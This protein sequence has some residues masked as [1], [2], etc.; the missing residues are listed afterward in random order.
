MTALA[1]RCLAVS[2]AL[3]TA[4]GCGHQV[5]QLEE[6]RPPQT[7]EPPRRG[8]EKLK[9]P[10]VESTAGN[11]FEPHLRR[12]IGRH[13]AGCHGPDVQKRR[14]R[15]DTL[16]TAF[17]DRGV[18]ATWVKVLDRVSRGDMPPANKPRPPKKDLQTVVG[19]LRKHLHDASL[20][21]QR[22]EGR[23]V[24]RRLNRTEY[25]TTLRDLLGAPVEVKD[26]LPDDNVAAGFDNVSAVLDVSAAHL[27]R[28]QEAAERAIRSVIPD[29]PQA[30]IEERRTG[31]QVTRNMKLFASIL[32]KSARLDGDTL[33]LHTRTWGHIPCA[34]APA[35]V[36]G[37]YRVRVSA[38]AVGTGGKPLPVMFVCR[39][40]YG[41]EDT[42]VRG[43]RDVP[44]GKAA[45]VEGEFELKPRQV[46]VINGWSLPSERVPAAQAETGRCPQGPGP[47]RGLDRDQ[48][49]PRAVASHRVSESFLRR[50]AE[51]AIGGQGGSGGP[52]CPAA[53]R[54]ATRW[55]V[56]LRSAG[57]GP[58]KAA[59]GRRTADPGFPPKGVPPPRARGATALLRQGGP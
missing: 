36:A 59:P 27:L 21:R 11:D 30:A 39:D 43:V 48:R 57:H 42:D 19:T 16:P 55:L 29:R 6:N 5:S 12:F 31:R 15:L 49:S 46:I 51:A 9:A 52:P 3:V 45:V 17:D 35:P 54:Q 47:G 10:S 26:L 4:A 28:Y 56:D 44:A 14:L 24:L 33:I 1:F 13:C 34:T 38:A 20:A 53:A 2:L 40:L 41:R 22:R 58:E 7:K 37:R 25:Q 23:V 8:V 50:A 18:S 32:G